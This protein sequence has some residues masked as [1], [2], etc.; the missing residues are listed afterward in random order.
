[1]AN[2][3]GRRRRSIVPLL[4]LAAIVLGIGVVSPV[5]A[6]AAQNGTI[7]SSIDTCVVLPG[8]AT[9]PVGFRVHTTG[10]KNFDQAVGLQASACSSRV[11]V[12]SGQYT[13]AQSLTPS[14]WHLAQINCF[15]S[16]FAD[17]SVGAVDLSSASVT[18]KVA[19]PTV[20]LFAELPGG[21][22][23]LGPQGSG[24]SSTGK[25]GTTS[26]TSTSTSTSTTT[27]TTKSTTPSTFCVQNPDYPPN[28]PPYFC[29]NNNT[30]IG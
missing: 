17:H 29:T 4:V 16:G 9:P 18:I 19:H 2:D 22:G 5:V 11:Q 23:G 1:M 25:S 26:S 12:P 20:C 3:R 15:I 21:S 6:G 14:G 27:T 10:P 24:S 28:P 8:F 13:V 7:K 30:T